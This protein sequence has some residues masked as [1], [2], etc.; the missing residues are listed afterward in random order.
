MECKKIQDNLS[1]YFDG[2]L[3]AEESLKVEEHIKVCANCKNILTEYTAIKNLI[4]SVEEIEPR[5]GAFNQIKVRIIEEQER[6]QKRWRFVEFSFGTLGLAAA[7][8]LLIVLLHHRSSVDDKFE[9]ARN[10]EILQ[11]MEL[12]QDLDF[13]E[14]LANEFGEDI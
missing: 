10:L 6:I 7:G 5:E 1:L 9:I 4:Q 3:E 2:K 14:Y 12:I 13:Y 8:I 11:N